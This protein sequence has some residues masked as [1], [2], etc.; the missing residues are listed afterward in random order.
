MPRGIDRSGDPNNDLT[1][2]GLA[3]RTQYEIVAGTNTGEQQ[4]SYAL[5]S[6]AYEPS[7]GLGHGTKR[8]GTHEEALGY[9]E[10]HGLELKPPEAKLPPSD[11]GDVGWA[12]RKRT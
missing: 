4:R 6:N 12:G 3:R 2:E 8:F 11:A 1:R 10:H 9:V 7:W 5:V